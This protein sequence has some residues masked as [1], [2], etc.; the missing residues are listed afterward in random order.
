MVQVP[1]QFTHT[2]L[3]VPLPL[4]HAWDSRLLAAHVPAQLLHLRL[5]EL[6]GDLVW[7]WPEPQVRQLEHLRLLVPL[8]SEHARDSYVEPVH[9]AAQ[10]LHARLREMVGDVVWYW[11]LPHVVHAVHDLPL[12]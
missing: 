2:R 9:E 1:V 6:V 3:L 8:P 12:R 10:L 7:Y 4:E 5:R 11:P